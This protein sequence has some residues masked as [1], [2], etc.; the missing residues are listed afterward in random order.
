MGSIE[1]FV[2]YQFDSFWWRKRYH[3]MACRPRN[4]QRS[5]RRVHLLQVGVDTNWQTVAFLH[6]CL[7]D[8]WSNGPFSKQIAKPSQFFEWTFAMV[9]DMHWKGLSI[10]HPTIAYL[11]QTH[12]PLDRIRLRPNQNE[13][14]SSIL[15]GRLPRWILFCFISH[16][17]MRWST[18]TPVLWAL[19][20]HL[21]NMVC[22]SFSC[23]AAL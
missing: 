1:Q 9:R 14:L 23:W 18:D 5:G 12:S 13:S 6:H 17:S 19:N 22:S 2:I 7:P 20:S 4:A 15:Y 16:M 21:E 11:C 10:R 3:R 8:D